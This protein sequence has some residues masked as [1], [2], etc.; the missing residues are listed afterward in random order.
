MLGSSPVGMTSTS[1][2]GPLPPPE[3]PPASVVMS[4]HPLSTKIAAPVR[5]EAPMP[6]DATRRRVVGVFMMLPVASASS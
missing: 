4:V 6:R 1:S 5:S 2:C 3:P